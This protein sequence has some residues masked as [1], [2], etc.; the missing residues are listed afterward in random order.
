M[1][2]K[3]IAHIL[4]PDTMG[5]WVSS[6]LEMCCP[7]LCQGISEAFV[8]LRRSQTEMEEP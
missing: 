4:L 2:R 7:G 3:R 6:S 5:V 1:E 8:D